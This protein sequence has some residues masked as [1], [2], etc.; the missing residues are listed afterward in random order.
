MKRL[1]AIILSASMLLC[2][3]AIG[4]IGNQEPRVFTLGEEATENMD[5]FES[6]FQADTATVTARG[7]TFILKNDTNGD[8][9]VTG[10]WE[11]FSCKLPLSTAN[12]ICIEHDETEPY[13]K[14]TLKP[15][16]SVAISLDWEN[17]YGE[18][19]E[20]AYSLWM[21]ANVLGSDGKITARFDVG[22]PDL[23]FS[24]VSSETDGAFEI[25]SLDIID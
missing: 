25:E 14:T 19:P 8:I 24:G 4:G 16:E 15:G 11:I 2:G 18:F 9:V 6:T 7:A 21:D 22:E 23:D 12:Y 10:G 5:F 3:C 13:P 20:G 1:F 17:A